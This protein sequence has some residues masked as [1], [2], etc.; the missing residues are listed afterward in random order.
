MLKII[1]ITATH[2]NELGGIGVVLFEL[3]RS[4]NKI[5]EVDSRLI[6]LKHPVDSEI[7]EYSVFVPPNRF[8]EYIENNTPNI[9]V[10]HS[11]FEVEYA[12]ISKILYKHQIPYLI[13]PHG[14]FMYTT[15]KKSRI[16][17]EIADKT[18]FLKLLKN[19]K[20][21]I[22]LNAEEQQQSIRHKKNE[23]IIPNGVRGEDV[24]YT[25]A[26]KDEIVFYYIGRFDV[27]HK[28]LDY[29]LDSLEILDR[30]GLS[31]KFKFYGKGSEDSE[32][33]INM[34]V[35]QFKNMKV[36]NCGPIYGNE[37]N[38]RL[39]QC[40]IMVLTSRYEGFPM[41]TLEA[42]KYGN[43]CIVTPGTNVTELVLKNQLGW[44]CEQ[45]KEKIAIT[46]ENAVAAYANNRVEYI[47][48]TKKYVKETFEWDTIGRISIEMLK[49][50]IGNGKRNG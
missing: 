19:A 23:F 50:M 11:Y 30:K 48:R 15:Y 47:N 13:E 4:Q 18:V 5:E 40:G 24:N 39:E 31:L 2:V 12:Y 10:I 27:N 1:H 45:D 8:R 44:V 16:R 36:S 35:S 29:L 28:G 17:K 6:S 21:Y 26:P 38:I 42:W 7:F 43:P 25:I 46:I 9:A 37:K 14:G 20:G 33:Y 3:I 41:T 49:L 22:F 34:R 32:R